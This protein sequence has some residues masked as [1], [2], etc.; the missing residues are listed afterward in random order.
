VDDP[1]DFELPA[2]HP[3]VADREYRARRAAI[4][5]TAERFVEG[6]PIPD[7]EYTAEEDEV[8]RRVSSELGRKHDR[9]ACAAFLDGAARLGLRR[10]RVPQLAEVSARL[11]ELTD[12]RLR[13]TGGLV[14]TRAFYGSLAERTFWSTQYVRHHSVPFYTPEPDVIHEVIGH[15]N[16]LADPGFA[17]LYQAAGEASRRAVGDDALEFFS[18][19]FWFSLEFGVLWEDGEL[20]T[21]GAGLLSS[22]AEIDLFRKAE[23]RPLDITAMG[24]TPY[25]I[26]HYQPLLFAG[27]SFAQVQDVLGAFFA[28]YDDEMFS[29]LTHAVPRAS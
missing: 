15:A 26:T 9:Y 18:R 25:D 16:A 1:A 2:D 14:P 28:G 6:G 29:R 4:A 8:W 17:A 22:Y 12:F 24:T 21:Y 5:A 13:P 10:D 3:G 27:Q 7:V 23:V 20:R 19:V 11:T